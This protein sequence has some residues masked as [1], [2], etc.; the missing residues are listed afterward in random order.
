MIQ[1][2]GKQGIG[3]SKALSTQLPNLQ[4]R[5]T[6]CALAGPVLYYYNGVFCYYYSCAFSRRVITSTGVDSFDF[7]IPHPQPG[8]W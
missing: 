8:Q 3:I 4:I 5:Y 7:R 6:S 1:T 2:E